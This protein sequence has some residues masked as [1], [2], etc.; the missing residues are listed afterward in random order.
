MHL[1]HWLA[2]FFTFSLNV[3]SQTT[4]GSN[5]ETFK[6]QYESRLS[7]F[8][9]SDLSS[10]EAF[11][12]Q[13]KIQFE[14][15]KEQVQARWRNF[16][17]STQ[18]KFVQYSERLDSRT[19][20]DFE[21]GT[22]EL[23]VQIDDPN[24]KT[25]SREAEQK[26]LKELKAIVDVK[27]PDAIS[28]VEDQ[29]PKDILRPQGDALD[30]KKAA[31]FIRNQKPKKTIVIAKDRKKRIQYTL[32]VPLVVNHLDKRAKKYKKIID[33]QAKRFDISPSLV[34]AITHVES[35]FNPMAKSHIPAYGLMQLVPESGGR[36]AYTSLFDRDWIPSDRYLFSPKNNIE[37]GCQYLAILKEKYFNSVENNQSK[38]YCVIAGYNT[39]AGNVARAFTGKKNVNNATDKIN[40]LNSEKV[41]QR[42]LQRLPYKETKKYLREVLEKK[43]LYI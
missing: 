40:R 34:M 37:L 23:E 8:K 20:V 33:R 26:I 4:T 17:S 5:L 12:D 16:K 3:S 29:L 21:S 25:A 13:E 43:K 32:E 24:S 42:L 11:K 22:I 2:I 9:K 27:D 28:I 7:D 15:F 38:E 31:Q 35:H 39:G 1:K 19:E 41:K 30:V 10:Y 14:A 18:K 6:E 36:H